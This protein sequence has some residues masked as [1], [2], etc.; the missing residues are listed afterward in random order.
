MVATTRSK[1]P[2]TVTGPRSNIKKV[3]FGKKNRIRLIPP[4]GSNN[5]ANEQAKINA[6]VRRVLHQN[7]MNTSLQNDLIN[8][9][10]AQSILAM[11]AQLRNRRS[12]GESN[13]RRYY[14]TMRNRAI[15]NN[16]GQ[17]NNN[18][19]TMLGRIYNSVMRIIGY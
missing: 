10:I 13:N 5:Y 12:R 4:I 3:S 8:K 14:V 16:F 2:V 9:Q 6:A 18:S 7:N 11:K 19:R 15:N 17:M 1:T